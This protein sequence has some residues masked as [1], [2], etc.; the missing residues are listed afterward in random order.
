M[1]FKLLFA[2]AFITVSSLSFGQKS[3]IKAREAFVSERFDE[4]TE[5]CS[6]AYT[7]LTR[8]GKQAKKKKGEMA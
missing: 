2:V 8:K 1:N 6:Q 3:V 4:A 7:K 5:L